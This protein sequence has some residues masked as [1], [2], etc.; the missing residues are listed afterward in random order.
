M[1]LTVQMNLAIIGLRIK[2]YLAEAM[3]WQFNVL[4]A[5]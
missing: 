4:K 1:I 3:K 2:T 5:S